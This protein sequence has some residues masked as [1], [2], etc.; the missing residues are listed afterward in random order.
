MSSSLKSRSE[1]RNLHKDLIELIIYFAC[2]KENEIPGIKKVLLSSIIL[3]SC[4]FVSDGEE[5]C[6]HYGNNK[7][8]EEKLTRRFCLI[9]DEFGDFLHPDLKE[10]LYNISEFRKKM[11]YNG[12]YGNIFYDFF[13]FHSESKE[14]PVINLPDEFNER[15]EKEVMPKLDFVLI[16]QCQSIGELTI[17]Y[18]K[19]D[20]RQIKG[21]KTNPR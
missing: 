21:R 18:L 12:R 19:R 2:Q 3:A 4:D 15:I 17:K 10:M 8:W 14:R 6:Q 11:G 1:K 20:I 7:S 16:E 13:E 9:I 5:I